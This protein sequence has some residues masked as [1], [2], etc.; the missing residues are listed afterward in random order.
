MAPILSVVL[1][2]VW[3]SGFSKSEIN[4]LNLPYFLFFAFITGFSSEK[5]P[6]LLRELSARI[7]G[8]LRWSDPKLK[9]AGEKAQYSF[10]VQD[11]SFTDVQDPP[12]QTFAE[13]EAKAVTLAKAQA[14][15]AMVD[16]VAKKGE[17]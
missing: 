7:F 13:A 9:R 16:D 5:I 14:R 6:S 12:A 2:A 8:G 17:T 10:A 11:L 3:A 15:K 1:A 4:F